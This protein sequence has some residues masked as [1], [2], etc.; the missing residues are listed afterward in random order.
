M[1][2]FSANCTGLFEDVGILGPQCHILMSLSRRQFV[3]GVT[4]RMYFA[5]RWN[6]STCPSQAGWCD[7]QLS[8]L[9]SVP[10]SCTARSRMNVLLLAFFI[11]SAS[12]LEII[13]RVFLPRVLKESKE[14]FMAVLSQTD[15]MG[16][17]PVLCLE[18]LPIISEVA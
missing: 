4:R 6:A 3:L 14:S 2:S 10:F 16:L 11:V 5:R 13:W 18:Y 7:A 17:A 12:D 8:S 15:F 1:T 9:V